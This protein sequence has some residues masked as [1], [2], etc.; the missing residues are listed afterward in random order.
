[1][2][3][4]AQNKMLRETIRR[5]KKKDQARNAVKKEEDEHEALRKLA[6][7]LLPTNFAKLLSAQIDKQIKSKRGIKYDPEFKKFALSFYFS[8]PRNYRQL[9]ESI[10]LPSVRSLQ[11][12]TNT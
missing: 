2:K 5:M 10:A 6:Y 1:M 9:K 4:K 11:L 7:K 3:L 12:F 8:S